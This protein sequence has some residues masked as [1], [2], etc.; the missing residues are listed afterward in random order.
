MCLKLASIAGK[1]TIKNTFSPQYKVRRC[2]SWSYGKAH[3]HIIIYPRIMWEGIFQRTRSLDVGA[4]EGQEQRKG[5]GRS[6]VGGG[7]S[8]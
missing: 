6:Y 2:H 7:R 1:L 5:G 8:L 4:C 3:R